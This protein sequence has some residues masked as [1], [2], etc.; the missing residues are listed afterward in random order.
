V[1]QKD[2][3]RARELYFKLLPLTDLFES[4]GKYV[5]LAKAGLE[6]MGR[7]IGEPRKPLLPPDPELHQTLKRILDTIL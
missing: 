2:F 3:E 6:M 5:Q 1:E 7:S 4:S